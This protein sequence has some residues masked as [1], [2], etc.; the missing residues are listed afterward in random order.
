MPEEVKVRVVCPKGCR[1]EGKATLAEG[2]LDRLLAERTAEFV[3]DLIGIKL[4]GCDTSD[5]NAIINHLNDQVCNLIA[6]WKGV[7]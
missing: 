2:E 7:R 4:S 3:K 5:P 1:G 6:K